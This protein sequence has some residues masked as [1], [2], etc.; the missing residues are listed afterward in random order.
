MAGGQKIKTKKNKKKIAKGT[1]DY[2][3]CL[4]HGDSDHMKVTLTD[5]SMCLVG[6]SRA[7]TLQIPQNSPVKVMCTEWNSTPS[8]SVK[9]VTLLALSKHSL[10]G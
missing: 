5:W 1:K 2:S 8:K 7:S 10:I 6:N 3:H 9:L 4:C